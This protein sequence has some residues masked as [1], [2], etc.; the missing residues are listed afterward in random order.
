MKETFNWGIDFP[1]VCKSCGLVLIP[2][3]DRCAQCDSLQKRIQELESKNASLRAFAREIK[4]GLEEIKR[5]TY[6]DE[7]NELRHLSVAMCRINDLA[8]KFLA[9]SAE[10]LE[11]NER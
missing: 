3:T 6:H 11:N 10:V 5:D 4:E 8:N 7:L 9:K 1:P 2:G